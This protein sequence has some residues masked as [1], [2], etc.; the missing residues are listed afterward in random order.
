MIIAG[1]SHQAELVLQCSGR[2]HS[3]NIIA[4]VLNE[5]RLH[6]NAIAAEH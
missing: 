4:G 6:R 1:A 2:C 3:V 5:Q